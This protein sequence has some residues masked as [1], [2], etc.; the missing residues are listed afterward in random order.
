MPKTIALLLK[1]AML[2]VAGITLILFA[3]MLQTVTAPAPGEYYYSDFLRNNYTLLAGVLFFI[4][5][6]FIG[7]YLQLNPW[8]AGLALIAALPLA[9]F[10]E[11]AVYKG[12][13]NLIPF[14][15]VIYFLFSVP[16]IAG[17]Y[18]G[19]YFATRKKTAKQKTSK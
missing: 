18:A 6:I 15:L 14:E 11:A 2:I 1:Y 3:S 8:L 13:H 7:Y 9:S 12:S 16:A 4:A 10:Y 19:N 5:G 17:V